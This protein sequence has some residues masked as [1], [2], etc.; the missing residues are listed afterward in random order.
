[1]IKRLPAWY[2]RHK[3]LFRIFAGLVIVYTLAGFAIAPLIV[4]HILEKNASAALHRDVRAAAVR[5]NPFTFSLRLTDL[6]IADRDNETPFV[7]IGRLVVN[8][9]PLISLFKWGMVI[10][11]VQV[12]APGIRIIRTSGDQFNFSDLMARSPAEPSK[13]TAP[14]SKPVR[15]VVDSFKLV[16]GEIR[17]VDNTRGVPFET[18]V[19]A[20]EA[21][22]NGLDTRPEAQPFQYA[23]LGVTEAD[24]R[25][26]VRG[27]SDIHPFLMEAR[28]TLEN[29]SPAKYAPYYQSHLNAD[30]THGRI[31]IHA[32]LKWD[33]QTR[34]VSGL[35]ITV[36]DLVLKTIE[37]PKA[38]VNLPRFIVDDAGIDFWNRQ[39]R[40][41]RINSKDARI[42]VQR[43]AQGQLNLQTAF[44][45]RTS[46]STARNSTGEEKEKA[47][48]T[49][50]WN[51]Y[52]PELKLEDYAVE[53]EDLQPATPVKTNLS[54]ISLAAG[55]L[56]N[57]PQ[58]KGNIDL[59]LHW[60]DQGTL[61]ARGEVGLSPLQAALDV[62][63]DKLDILP[64]QSY[65]RE[66]VK[67]VFTKGEFS[68][69]GRIQV[70]PK[71]NTRDLRF[72][73]QASLDS[74]EAVDAERAALFTKWKSLYLTGVHIGT[75]PP[76]A[77]I[78]KVALTDFYN[79][80][81][82][83]TDGTVNFES[84]LASSQ[85]SPATRQ[86]AKASSATGARAD[87][88]SARTAAIVIKAITLQGGRVDFNDQYI[89][90]NV[91][92]V[93]EDLGGAISGLDTFEENTADVRLRGRMG[94]NVPLEINGRVNPLIKKPFVDLSLDF[95]N[96]D[97]SPFTPYSGKYLGYELEKGQ[98]SFS[99][100]Y[101]VADNKL[102]GRNQIQLDQLT[103]GDSV[104]SPQAT[105]L[106]IK[107]AV[108]LLKD[109]SGNIDLDLPVA[110]DLDDPKFSLGG[111]ILKMF[112]NLIT[113]IATSP[114][115]VLGAVFGSGEELA[116]LAF[117]PGRSAI[118]PSQTE[119][120][121]TLE[122]ILFERP[123][124]K[125]EIQGW[126][127]PRQDTQGLR[128]LRFEEQLKSGKLKK[129]VAAGRKAVPLDRIEIAPQERSAMVQKA[130][131]AADFPKPRDEK[132]RLKK[133]PPPEMEKLLYT[134]INIGSDDLRRLAHDRAAAAKAYL[135]EK[136]RIDS[137]RLFVVEPRVP[138]SNDGKDAQP[139]VQ[140]S[141]K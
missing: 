107:L 73:G 129:I 115:K 34:T 131:D 49:S 125:L 102:T 32:G 23:L 85:P 15:V 3:L 133:I 35:R 109:R 64:L 26:E 110:G 13:K 50:P 101:R 75:T 132:G 47:P 31:D 62:K 7:R 139:Q 28:A 43:N 12:D 83:N 106:P 65:F 122:E 90:P 42:F 100:A 138:G 22:V 118:S 89:K 44:A 5:T 20:L 108:A 66:F 130:F 37:D 136:G 6:T 84:I 120:L 76:R 113:Q 29:L 81:I 61:S 46:P 117:D 137:G 67:L 112:V 30:V 88:S 4:R 104:A 68:T 103:F 97:L 8:A 48:K 126:I 69:R 58:K 55:N 74:L 127:A 11:S 70:V 40:L 98:L 141:L 14:E 86:P 93:M 71:E 80:L 1:M 135:L 57:E 53:F 96:F 91:H 38:L 10:R 51:I 59:K 121:D 18:T 95:P 123:G 21:N 124:L 27:K 105:K 87:S 134:A 63:A 54:R 36:D 45:S 92:L 25:F 17:F 114:F 52:L 116:Y 24:E 33:V 41:G 111:V 99:L 128:R 60:A 119:K 19:T 2:T 56:S 82:I 78:D 140:F 9:D 39:I 94:G 77:E 16:S 79:R 72:A